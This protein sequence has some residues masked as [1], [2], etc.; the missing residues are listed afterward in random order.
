LQ[1]TPSP[2][3]EAALPLLAAAFITLALLAPASIAAA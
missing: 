1:L 3:E 2:I